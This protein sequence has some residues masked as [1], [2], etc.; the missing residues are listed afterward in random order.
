MLLC[1][2]RQHACKVVDQSES[3]PV[4]RGGGGVGQS[5]SSLFL[6]LLIE[7]FYF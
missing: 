5:E 1:K 2:N 3:S 6:R 7:C 4:G